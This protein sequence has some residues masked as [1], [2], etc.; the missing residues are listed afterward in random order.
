MNQILVIRHAEAEDAADAAIAGRRDAERALTKQGERQMR[1]GAGGL[2]H[3]TAEIRMIVSSP[4][5]RA[6]QTAAALAESYPE[7]EL[8]ENPRLAPGF[9]GGKLLAW[10]VK[11]PQPL[12][13]VGHEPDLSQWIG[14]L[15]TGSPRAIVNM[16][17]GSVCCL[18]IPD[19]VQAGEGRIRWFMTLKQLMEL[20]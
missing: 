6:V 2:R 14:Y 9:D 18:E 7:A 16:K 10:A 15:V 11:Q 12:A 13:L 20:D 3:I 17:K 1:K 5:R 8:T 4:L 19:S